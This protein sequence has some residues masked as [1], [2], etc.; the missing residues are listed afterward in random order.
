MR[1]KKEGRNKNSVFFSI[2]LTKKKKFMT[3]NDD[4]E[5]SFLP[6]I[7]RNKNSNSN[8]NMIKNFSTENYHKKLYDNI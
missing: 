7:P 2:R 4:N 8:K 6:Q 3:L 5:N 1:I